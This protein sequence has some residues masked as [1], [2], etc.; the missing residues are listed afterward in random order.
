MQTIEDLLAKEGLQHGEPF[1]GADQHIEGQ[2][3]L[4]IFDDTEYESRNPEG[5]I[6]KTPGAPPAPGRVAM[7]S[8][9][10]NFAFQD[11]LVVDHNQQHNSFLV[12]LASDQ[13]A[14]GM[15]TEPTN[16]SVGSLLAHQS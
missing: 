11:C 3:P 7:P 1:A 10:G 16:N 2:L 12:Q 6:N 4:A 5:W 9:D 14:S 13:S 8:S 15:A